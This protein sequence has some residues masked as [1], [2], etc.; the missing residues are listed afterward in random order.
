MFK[1]N[2][3]KIVSITIISIM[4]LIPSLKLLSYCLFLGGIIDNQFIINHVYVLWFSIP[5][6]LVLYILNKRELNITDLIIYG[7]SILGLL[8][9]ISALNQKVSILGALNRNEGLLT[10]ISYYLI[11][12]N[13]KNIDRKKIIKVFLGL[14]VFQVIY[15]V[16]QVFTKFKFIKHFS[17]PFLAMGLCGNPNFYGSLMVM[18][19]LIS[20]TI[21]LLDNKKR[22]LFLSILYFIGLCLAGSTGPFLGFIITFIFL[23]ISRFKKIHLKSLVFVLITFVFIYFTVNSANAYIQRTTNKVVDPN[24][25]I[26]SEIL[27]IKNNQNYGNGRIQI[28]KNSVPLIEKY[29]WFGAGIDNFSEAYKQS[30]GVIVDKAHNVYIQILVT[31]GIYALVLNLILLLI[32]FIK[33]FKNTNTISTALFMAF[34]GYSIQAFANISVIDVAPF[35][36]IIM[37]MLSSFKD[38]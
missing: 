16:L 29:F 6:L 26:N 31:N 1:K 9:T 19:L 34:I 24:Y 3:E 14:G 5:I 11:F 37:G 13:S 28:W 18:L 35:Y 22:Y 32:I 2:L 10:L 25:N 33:C 12:L 15:G 7:L 17:K 27:N 23:L 21:Y 8:S 20:V 4:I 30:G 36:F 38:N